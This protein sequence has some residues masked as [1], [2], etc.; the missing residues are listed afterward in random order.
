MKRAGT[1]RMRIACLAGTVWRGSK[2]IR[3]R[4]SSPS[5]P[6]IWP[7]PRYRWEVRHSILQL[8]RWCHRGNCRRLS[9]GRHLHKP[10]E[11]FRHRPRLL[12]HIPRV[13]PYTLR[14]GKPIQEG[15]V[16]GQ[17]TLPPGSSSGT[18]RCRCTYSALRNRWSLGTGSSRT[19]QTRSHRRA[20]R[21]HRLRTLSRHN[22]GSR[23]RCTRHPGT[24]Y[25]GDTAGLPIHFH[26]R[27][28]SPE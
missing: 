16:R 18:P 19:T 23:S 4:S 28:K 14:T 21:T 2:Q 9:T 8:G 10:R 26:L 11:C 12:D 1:A 3:L 13:G 24:S 6:R 20:H 25:S 22:W 15:T 7:V 5:C 27:C 17:T